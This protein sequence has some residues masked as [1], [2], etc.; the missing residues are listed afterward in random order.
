M[1]KFIT[2]TPTLV[3]PIVIPC[4]SENDGVINQNVENEHTQATFE[5]A[6]VNTESYFSCNSLPSSKGDS[7]CA[8]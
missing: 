3:V 1:K 4:I 8:V 6:L 5:L 7:P 2:I